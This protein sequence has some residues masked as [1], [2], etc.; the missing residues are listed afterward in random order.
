MGEKAPL[1]SK[2][3]LTNLTVKGDLPYCTLSDL[4]SSL[5]FSGGNTPTGNS[6]SAVSGFGNIFGYNRG[7]VN[8]KLLHMLD[9]GNVVFSPLFSL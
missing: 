9:Y 6:P 2:D 4:S 5:Y 8:Y 1:Q 7:D 3:L